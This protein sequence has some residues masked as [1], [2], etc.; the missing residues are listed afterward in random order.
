M[1]E[2]GGA[3]ADGLTRVGEAFVVHPWYQ[4]EAVLLRPAGLT[5]PDDPALGLIEGLAGYRADAPLRA[6]RAVL[7]EG[8]APR[9]DR[10]RAGCGRTG[11]WTGAGPEGYAQDPT[12]GVPG[13]VTE[14]AEAHG[15]RRG[16]RRPLPATARPARPDRPQLHALD[17]LEARPHEEGP[18]RTRRDRT[19]GGGEARPR[20]PQPV[21]ARRLAGTQGARTA[22]RVL[23][24]RPC[25]TSLATPRRS[26]CSPS[27][28]CSPARGTGYAPATSRPS[29]NSRPARPG[30]G[31]ADDERG[32]AESPR[33]CA[34][35]AV[36]LRNGQWRP[37]RTSRPGGA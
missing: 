1:P 10:G 36:G 16:R 37:G 14:V 8:L 31:G 19:G 3:G 17:R 12:R 21:P 6:I 32:P 26:R 22:G 35:C 15:H 28:N 23:E 9:G 5:G 30:R 24:A 2:T 13:L 25:T 27:R 20:G 34:A 7:G 11:G 33:R 4:Q 18:R 29:K